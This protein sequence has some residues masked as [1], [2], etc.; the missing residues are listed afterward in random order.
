MASGHSIY[1]FATKNDYA[2]VFADVS[3][4]LD[5]KYV[6]NEWRIEPDFRVYTSPLEVHDFNIFKWPNTCGDTRFL[7]L[8]IDTELPF[9]YW[10]SR[11]VPAKYGFMPIQIEDPPNYQFVFFDPSGFHKSEE[12]GEGLIP[13]WISTNSEHPDSLAIFNAFK[14]SIRKHFE[15]IGVY[16]VGP[17]AAQYLDSGGRL[18][19]DLRA[20]RERYLRRPDESEKGKALR[21]NDVKQFTA[22]LEATIDLNARDQY[23]WTLIEMAVL[24]GSDKIV[25]FL[26]TQKVELGQAPELAQKY[27]ASSKEHQRS[28]KL[29]SQ[30]MAKIKSGA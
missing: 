2:T 28:F 19:N 6:M 7:V 23:G 21:K 24:N 4:K 29:L 15:R 22:A 12:W 3:S 20:T 10:A 17:E 27:S 1:H 5:I 26:I 25:E 18:G 16:Y 9:K 11:Q 14:K 13:G 30:Y 8:P